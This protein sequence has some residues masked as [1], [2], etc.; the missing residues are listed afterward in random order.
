MVMDESLETNKRAN[1][2]FIKRLPESDETEDKHRADQLFKDTGCS[3]AEITYTM[4]LGGKEE[5]ET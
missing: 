2:L 4:R 5:N 1:D 3:Y